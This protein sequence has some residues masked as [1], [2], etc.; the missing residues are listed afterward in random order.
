MATNLEI[1]KIL[2]VLVAAYPNAKIIAGDKETP[3]TIEVYATMLADIPADEL[4]AAV[5]Y[6]INTHPDFM[7]TIATLRQ[8]HQKMHSGTTVSG[9]DAWGV[10]RAA[11]RAHGHLD[12][13]AFADPA[14][15]RAVDAFG[16]SNLCMMD[17]QDFAT[18][19]QFMK[20]YE[21]YAQRVREEDQLLGIPEARWVMELIAGTA[22]RLEAVK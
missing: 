11:M 7:P 16:W 18:R 20:A 5:K 22:K 2:R 21:S 12:K 10:V 6:A 17:T 3:G 4:L 8:A 15:A 19:S 14:I 1:T 13:P 9:A